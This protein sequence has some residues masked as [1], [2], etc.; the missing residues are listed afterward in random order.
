V[1]SIKKFFAVFALLF[2]CTLFLKK[3]PEEDAII[4]FERGK[5]SMAN[6]RYKEAIQSFSELIRKYPRSKFADNAYYLA[7]VCFYR[8]KDYEHAKGAGINMLKKY[9]ASP[10]K[11]KALLLVAKSSR[12]TQDYTTATEYYLKL[13]TFTK[14]KRYL[15]EAKNMIARLNPS[16]IEKVSKKVKNKNLKAMLLFYEIE[17][18]KKENKTKEALKK[19]EILKKRFPKTIY[20]DKVKRVVSLVR[21]GV[22]LS[23]SGEFGNVAQSVR[24]GIEISRKIY[25]T[26]NFDIIYFDTEDSEE[27]LI[28]GLHYLMNRNVDLIIGPLRS[29]EVAK[30]IKE[31]KGSFPIISPTA[32]EHELLSSYPCL[33]EMNSYSYK[34]AEEIAR[35]ATEKL[36]MQ[37]FA[38]IA[39]DD[40]RTKE[41]VSVFEK[42]VEMNQGKVV[43]CIFY[44]DTTENFKDYV[45]S[46]RERM[47]D[48]V[49]LP[50]PPEDIITIAPQFAYY[51]IKTVILGLDEFGARM[52]MEKGIKYIDNAI[53]VSPPITD[54]YLTDEII[55]D[56][57][58]KKYKEEFKSPPDWAAILGFDTFTLIYQ[59]IKENGKENLCENLKNTPRRKGII[60]RL[61]FGDFK[62]ANP[63]FFYTIKK[64]KI[65]ELK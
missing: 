55:F 56:A 18:L 62:F 58:Y 45:L 44:P 10:L 39:P 15:E 17:K 54:F 60:G 28:E 35:Y 37:R 21:I 9:P 27:K 33:F 16:E 19:S 47:V 48:G 20:A 6:K 53:F 41:I 50:C 32:T 11:E 49:F 51:K 63:F 5:S 38:V 24:R 14:N 22:L 43:F 30:I 25:D 29:S 46:L 34:E 64:G 65:K 57:F 4:L 3:P 26:Q 31:I 23:F 61:A 52:V 42:T 8:E 7:G 13:Y 2:S 1:K 12:L 36:F 59:T 40:E